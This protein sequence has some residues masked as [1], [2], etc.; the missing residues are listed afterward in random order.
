MTTPIATASGHSFIV[1]GQLLSPAQA[2]ARS[3]ML[4]QLLTYY[5][6]RYTDENCCGGT[7]NTGYA[8]HQRHAITLNFDGL[9]QLYIDELGKQ[10]PVS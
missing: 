1:N 9:K 8:T 7:N 4:D 10:P 5:H 2:L 3:V 6:R